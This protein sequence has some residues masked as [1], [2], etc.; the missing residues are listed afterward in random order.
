MQTKKKILV[1]RRRQQ[2]EGKVTKEEKIS[3]EVI[4]GH[5]KKNYKNYDSYIIKILRQLHPDTGITGDSIA[6]MNNILKILIRKI[7]ESAN[8]LLVHKNKESKTLTSREIYY[9]VELTLPGEL[10]KHAHAE[11]IK[12]ITKFYDTEDE[13]R[14]GKTTRSFRAGLL[15]SISRVEKYMLKFSVTERKSPRAAIILTAVCEY[16]IAEILEIAGNNSR[17]DHKV[18]IASKFITRAIKTDEE[19]F[20]LF[21]DTFFGSNTYYGLKE[22]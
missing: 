7:M 19:L 15:L 11:G 8:I 21:G 22:D 17:H 5:K 13:E 20:A 4:K 6:M 9:S 14:T 10:M 16:I 2:K 1:E 3:K 18:R 12:A